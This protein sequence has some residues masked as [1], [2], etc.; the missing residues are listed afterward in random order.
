MGHSPLACAI[1]WRISLVVH[2]SPST[3][4]GRLPLEACSY[5]WRRQL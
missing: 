4:E 5:L 2:L 1:A 3:T